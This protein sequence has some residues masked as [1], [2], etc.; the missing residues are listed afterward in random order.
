MAARIEQARQRPRTPGRARHTVTGPSLDVHATGRGPTLSDD[1]HERTSAQRSAAGARCLPGAAGG[2][3]LREG[4]PSPHRQAGEPSVGMPDAHRRGPFRSGN[5][6]RVTASLRSLPLP[7]DPNLAAYASALNDAG[8]WADVFDATWRYV[9]ATD[10]LRLSRGDRG[11]VTFLPIGSHLFSAEFTQFR[12]SM[13]RGGWVLPEYR[14]A[15]FL[16]LGPYVLASTPGGREE[17][18]RVVDPEFVDLVDE[19]QP[20]DLPAVWA[21]SAVSST[22]AGI[23]VVGLSTV[24][25]IDDADGHVAGF[26]SLGKPAAG[27]SQLAA[28]AQTVDPAHLERMQAVEHADRR[29][30]AILMADL[31]ASS[32][33]AR[34]LST[35]SYFA[36]SR[37][38]V[39]ATDRCVVDAGG[40][41]GRHAGDGVVAFFLAE[42]IGS[43]SA[44][45]RSCIIAA[46]ALRDTLTEI[47]AR[48]EIPATELSLRFGL[49]WGATLYIG[50]IL[51][52]GRSEVTALGDEVNEGA[53]I[54]ACATGGRALA[55]KS[56]IERL[57]RGD[58]D[59]L[60]INTSHT[61][62][63][64]L[65]DLATATDK[66]RRDA[67][68][69][70]V[71]E[72]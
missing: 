31:E 9:F 60:G 28:A 41:V 16:Q 72:V 55:S 23:D 10:E 65:A 40:I 5:L 13:Y 32:P 6:T 49:H 47:A 29:P 38:L 64:P 51:T 24:L 20:N 35:E 48:A 21:G 69:I 8:H 3:G 25:R 62:Y 46:R 36:F 34:R 66:A 27:M 2:G 58:A 17:L 43:E 19:L 18:R 57:N 50:R 4:N 15:H 42:S 63:T 45:A 14:R 56:L 37:R 30:A 68:S 52:A 53:R 70:A 22:S 44:A 39:R 12:V 67:P 1:Q 11:A 54:E 26:C 33:L 7:D 61:T 59:A 71:C